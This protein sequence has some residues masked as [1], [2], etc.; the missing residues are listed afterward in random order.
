MKSFFKNEYQEIFLHEEEGIFEERFTEASSE[1]FGD[2]YIREVSIFGDLIKENQPEIPYH[3]LIIN[4][5]NG[6]PT[7]E[8]RVQEFMHSTLYPKLWGYGIRAKA[9]CLGAEIISK[10]SVEL[11]AKG[12]TNKENE[13]SYKFCATLEEGITFL[14][15]Q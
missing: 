2:A 3:K 13:F 11:T 1:I 14:N 8:P 7:M 5:L 6:G 12:N 9:Y 10:L 4:T 15:E